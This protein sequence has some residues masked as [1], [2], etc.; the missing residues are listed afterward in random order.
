M[1]T[2]SGMNITFRLDAYCSSGQQVTPVLSMPTRCS[3]FDISPN[4]PGRNGND[5]D[6]RSTG[7]SGRSVW[8][9]KL[10]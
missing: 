10:S 8:R 4:F 7:A 1:K 9:F 2:R 3:Y 5:G 6:T